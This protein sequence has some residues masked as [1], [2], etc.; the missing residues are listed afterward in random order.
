MKHT[1]QR[2]TR[3]SELKSRPLARAMAIALSLAA[4]SAGAAEFLVDSDADA[5]PGTLRDA[6]AQANALAG[7]D[8]IT[9]GQIGRIT[10]TS[11]QIDITESLI[12]DGR[13]RGTVISGND[14][15]RIFGVTVQ[16]ESLE[17]LDLVL[18]E[19]RAEDTGGSGLCHAGTSGGGAICARGPLRLERTRILDSHSVDGR[20]GAVRVGSSGAV[21]LENSTI[22][23][24][25]SSG[26]GG[27]MEITAGSLTI[28]NSK[29]EDNSTS[30]S[31]AYGG[32][33]YANAL[34]SIVGS[35]ITGNVTEGQNGK[36]AGLWLRGDTAIALSTISGNASLGA[37]GA[38][39]ALFQREGNLRVRSATITDN[40]GVSG[41]AVAFND[42]PGDDLVLTMVNTILAGNT[43]PAG[44]FDAIVDNGG[45]ITVDMQA[46]LFGDAPGEVNGTSFANIFDDSPGLA[47]LADNGCF[48][49]AGVGGLGVSPPAACTLTHAV[50][51]GSPA[52]N[53]GSDQVNAFDQRGAGFP[54][55]F[56][57]DADIGAF[58]SQ[59]FVTGPPDL[60]PAHPVP[61]AS[62]LGAAVMAM[63]FGLLGMLGLDRRRR[64]GR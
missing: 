45:S 14:N 30:N 34:T 31:S 51:P 52:L 1:T 53:A 54:R 9:F 61:V 13:D 56:G 10:L 62:P 27:G 38:G 35:S 24:N 48:E 22:T 15:S 28:F 43:A 18:I 16:E 64:A 25:R 2:T 44:N 19:A 29:I 59:G 4:G 3:V 6:I 20:G 40:T 58:E 23:G 63:L 7:T 17:I 47:P 39:A 8:T 49:L 50:L 57:S 32:G 55:I 21:V 41:G 5:G 33:L 60:S 46:S 37:F 26:P 12:I 42:G 36:G 11:G